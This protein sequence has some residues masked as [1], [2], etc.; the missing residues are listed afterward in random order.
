VADSCHN[1]ASFIF[2]VAFF[3]R[4]NAVH[5]AEHA[6]EFAAMP[7]LIRLLM[8][9]GLLGG[10]AYGAMFALANFVQPKQREMSITIPQQRLT[11]PN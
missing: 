5:F 11:K 7:S 8:V 4:R 10:A 2:L 9:L 1:P 6:F 3:L